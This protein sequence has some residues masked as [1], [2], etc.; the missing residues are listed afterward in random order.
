MSCVFSN[1]FKPYK[2]LH[3]NLCKEM[4]GC[5]KVSTIEMGPPLCENKEAITDQIMQLRAR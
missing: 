4:N 3:M 5:R 1:V 2:R